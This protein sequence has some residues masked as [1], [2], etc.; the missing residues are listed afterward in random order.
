MTAVTYLNN[1]FIIAMPSLANP[2]FFHSVIY[3]C[4][5]NDEGALGIVI[6]RP[7][8]MR[9]GSIFKQMDIPVTSKTAS[10]SMVFAGGPMQQER[11]FVLHSSS[12]E[13][14]MTLPIS[15]GI[16]LTTS[17]D[18]IEAIALDEGPDSYIVALGYVGWSQGQLEQE[19]LT[20]AWLNCPFNKHILFDTPADNRWR[21]AANQMGININ[22]LT[23]P[24]G[25]A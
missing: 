12:K 14:D 13:W 1:Q 3:M 18:V 9:L 19:M 8:N 7:I 5:H 6:N 17:R 23:I 25:H 10:H 21:A 11:G 15:D 16:S 2:Y 4:Q 22:Q 20:N 24:A